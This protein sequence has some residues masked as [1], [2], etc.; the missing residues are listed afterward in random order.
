MS[1]V[2]GAHYQPFA[3]FHQQD[4]NPLFV[5]AAS[6]EPLVIPLPFPGPPWRPA[7]LLSLWIVHR[8]ALGGW[9]IPARPWA[10]TAV[11]SDSHTLCPRVAMHSDEGREEVAQPGPGASR[12]DD[13]ASHLSSSTKTTSRSL[14]VKV[15]LLK[16]TKTSL[17]STIRGPGE[18]T[19]VNSRSDQFRAQNS[20]NWSKTLSYE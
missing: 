14:K 3:P 16:Q 1:K 19:N 2:T 9:R 11:G 10:H 12:G 13:N 18:R 7:W 20:R 5:L 17:E 8:A 15:G 6:A 4:H